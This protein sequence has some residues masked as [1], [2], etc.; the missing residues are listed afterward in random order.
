MSYCS[1]VVV[2]IFGFALAFFYV[3]IKFGS[4]L[5]PEEAAK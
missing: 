5:K 4:N 3:T 2:V 1:S